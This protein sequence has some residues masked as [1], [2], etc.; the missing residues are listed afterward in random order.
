MAQQVYSPTVNPNGGFWGG[1]TDLASGV[2]D[3]INTN[4]Q[5]KA[6]VQAQQAAYQNQ[7]NYGF[8]QQQPQ[9]YLQPQQQAGMAIDGG[10]IMKGVLLAGVIIGGIYLIK[11]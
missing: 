8:Q 6:M 2:F 5:N 4:N 1:L 11:K 10:K 3:F 7:L 9:Q